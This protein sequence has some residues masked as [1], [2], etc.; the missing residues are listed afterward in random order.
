MNQHYS[1]LKKAAEVFHSYG[2]DLIGPAKNAH[3]IQQLHMDPIFVNGLI[4]ELEFQLQVIIQEEKLA[5]AS[6]PREII[7]LL[8][9]IPQ[10]N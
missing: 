6:T 5:R 7:E 4:F 9:E 2:I 3:L 1:L 10:D 8:L